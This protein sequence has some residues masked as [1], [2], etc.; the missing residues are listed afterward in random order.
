MI[1]VPQSNEHVPGTWKLLLIGKRQRR[2]ATFTCPHGHVGSLSDHEITADGYVHP[3]VLCMTDG[4]G[5]HEFIFLEGWAVD[6]PKEKE[7]DV[8]K[9]NP[10]A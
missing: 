9:T 6:A 2:S 5:F 4:C 1:T 7:T 3:S 10:S 8:S